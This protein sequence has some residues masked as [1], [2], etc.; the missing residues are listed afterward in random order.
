MPRTAEDTLTRIARDYD[1]IEIETRRNAKSPVH[2]TTIWI[3]PTSRGAAIRSAN[4]K[5]GRWWQEATA[6]KKVAIRAGRRKVQV[7]VEPVRSATGIKE[8]SDGYQEKYGTRWPDDTKPMVR[9]SILSTTLRLKEN[10]AK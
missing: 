9:R 2:R 1:E 6:N 7:R 5:R 4:G 3:V 10:K 8:V